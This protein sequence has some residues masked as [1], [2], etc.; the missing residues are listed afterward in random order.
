ML[1]QF[2]LQGEDAVEAERAGL[3]LEHRGAAHVGRDPHRR[4]LDVEPCDVRGLVTG[5]QEAHTGIRPRCSAAVTP[6]HHAS[7]GSR[8]G[9]A[10]GRSS[11][12]VGVSGNVN[13]IRYPSSSGVGVRA[14]S[15]SNTLGGPRHRTQPS[16]S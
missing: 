6:A 8:L 1:Q 7:S 3:Q 14:P 12:S 13:A 4:R 10:I 2:E 9:L 5:G 11:D 15:G 16:R